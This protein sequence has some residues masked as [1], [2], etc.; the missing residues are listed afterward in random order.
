MSSSFAEREVKP[1]DA[2]ESGRYGVWG[3]GEGVLIPLPLCGKLL[4][5]IVR[6]KYDYN[7]C[8]TNVNFVYIVGFKLL[9]IYP[10]I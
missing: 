1:E 6:I 2:A 3:V 4:S 5:S 9:R 7:F 8:A 10:L